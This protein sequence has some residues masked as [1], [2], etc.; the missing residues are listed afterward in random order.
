MT[1]F[2]KAELTLD[3]NRGDLGTKQHFNKEKGS[4]CIFSGTLNR[5][6]NLTIQRAYSTWGFVGDAEFQVPP[7]TH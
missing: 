5:L 1:K 4:Q 2:H 7:H 6:Y 3:S